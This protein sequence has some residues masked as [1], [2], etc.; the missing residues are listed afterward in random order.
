MTSLAWPCL[1]PTGIYIGNILHP[2]I[3]PNQGNPCKERISQI[4]YIYEDL[5]YKERPYPPR[6]ESQFY[7]TL[8]TPKP[9]QTKVY[10]LPQL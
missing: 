8:K 1:T 7:A 10:N 9:S 3:N 4:M 6:N 2:M 5:P